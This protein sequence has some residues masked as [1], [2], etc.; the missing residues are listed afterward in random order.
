[1]A[2]SAEA[3]QAAP[4]AQEAPPSPAPWGLARRILFRFAFCYL[5]L[6]AAPDPP[7]RVNLLSTIPWGYY[8]ARPY[9]AVWHTTVPWVAKSVF[10]VSGRA[11]TYFP[12]GSG[13]TTL[14]YVTNLCFVVVALVATLIWSVL[15]R[16]RQVYERLDY[17][18]R[19]F[20]RYTLAITLLGYGFAKIFPLQFPPNG[21]TRLIEPYGEF[22]PMGVL[23]S[24]MGASTAY[25]MFAGSCEAI[26]G[27]LLLFRRTNTVGALMASA[28]MLNVVVLNLC[29]DVPV[30]LYSANLLLMA[31]F[32]AAPEF[33]RLANVLVWNRPAAPRNRSPYGFSGRKA[34][35]AVA[36][37]Q[38]LFV[39]WILFG[40]IFGGWRTY[41]QRYGI[42]S[43]PPIY[44]LYHV[45]EFTRDGKVA[46]PLETD[47]Q[48]WRQVAAQFPVNLMVQT[49][50]GSV[51][52]YGVQYD[53]AKRQAVLNLG[54]AKYPLS[55]SQPDADHLLLDGKLG[56]EQLSVRL[57]KV[58]TSRMLL[59][60]RGFHWIAEFPFNR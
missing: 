47:V 41:Q 48:R 32:L 10:H 42:A 19:V 40:Q 39:G 35:V 27:F 13:D 57:E 2:G 38:I 18:L 37:F 36:G 25:T 51:R 45:V 4:S 24:F 44:G 29:Y 33:R 23:W 30:K 1:M 34:R 53:A 5:V 12:T 26:P 8:V 14:A 56:P 46:P 59:L 49:M 17:W 15:D 54:G 3:Q 31:L 21:F 50:D 43:R 22:S 20:I 52:Y 6:Y 55:Y 58:D 28:V 60:N 16:K 9:A 11:L 7:G